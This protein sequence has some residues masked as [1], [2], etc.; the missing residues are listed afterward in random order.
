MPEFTLAVVCTED[1]FIAREPGHTPGDWASFEEQQLFHSRVSAADWSI[2]GR[3]THEAVDRPERR[4]IIFS[5]SGEGTWRRPNQIWVNPEGLT[6]SDL[7]QLV[8][9]HHPLRFGL[10]LGGTAVHDWFLHH[11]AI[12]KIFLTIEP[13]RFGEGLPVFTGQSRYG[14]EEEILKRGFVRVSDRT[15]NE[16]GTRLMTFRLVPKRTSA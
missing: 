1:G 7:P 15:L 13:V 3:G 11:N 12:S 9:G 16:A 2:M 14:P 4:R 5:S 8:N 6:P 10:I